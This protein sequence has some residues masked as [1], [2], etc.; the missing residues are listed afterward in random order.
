MTFFCNICKLYWSCGYPDNQ[1][2]IPF[3]ICKHCIDGEELDLKTRTENA[4]TLSQLKKLEYF[5]ALKYW[6]SMPP[7]EDL[8]HLILHNSKML[9]LLSSL[10][11]VAQHASRGD[12]QTPILTL[13]LKKRVIGNY[14]IWAT[15]YARVWGLSLSECFNDKQDNN[16][17]RA[18]AQHANL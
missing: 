18:N 13:H 2:I 16:V 8:T 6:D 17:R 12:M 1:A 5:Y 15:H 3:K 4:I 10:T 9:G 11:E 7:F 14:L